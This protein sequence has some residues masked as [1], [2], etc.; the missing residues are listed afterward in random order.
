MSSVSDAGGAPAPGGDPD[1]PVLL[2]TVYDL[3][4]AEII[5]SKLRSAGIDA[6]LR[7]ESAGVVFG[8]MVDGLGQQDIMVRAGELEVARA[9]LELTP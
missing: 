4:E 3:V 2:A 1:E 6:F 7:H 9:A 5:M 8:L